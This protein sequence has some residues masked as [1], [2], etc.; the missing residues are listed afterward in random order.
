[1]LAAMGLTRL[2]S[3]LCWATIRECSFTPSPKETEEE[4]YLTT[5]WIH[6]NEMQMQRYDLCMDGAVVG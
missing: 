6:G 1:M 4:E 3:L 2:R 5:S